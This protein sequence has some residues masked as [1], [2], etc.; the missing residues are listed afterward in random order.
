MPRPQGIPTKPQPTYLSDPEVIQAFVDGFAQGEPVLLS[1][2]NLRTEPLFDSVQ[3]MAKEEGLVAT[4]N[5]SQSP[6]TALGRS[7]SHY[8]ESLRRAMAI[9]GFFP[10]AKSEWGQDYTF[11]YCEAPE[12][13]ELHCTTAREFWRA[14]W[15]RGISAHAGIALDVLIWSQ[16]RPNRREGWQSIRGIDCDTGQLVIKLLGGAL[17]V[18]G[19]DLVVWVRRL[20]KRPSMTRTQRRAKPSVRGYLRLNS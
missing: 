9:Q 10:V 1:N 5:L 12:D 2:Q 17:D 11:R 8:W 13:Y 18:Q 6:M 3:L 20:S 19:S 7:T 16:P 15:S 14:C 4:A